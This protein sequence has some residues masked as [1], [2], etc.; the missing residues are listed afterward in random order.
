MRA[1]GL[2]GRTASLRRACR[3]NVDRR[4]GFLW[5][6]GL[7]FRSTF[8]GHFLRLISSP[9]RTRKSFEPIFIRQAGRQPATLKYTL[10]VLR[11]I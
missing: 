9:S 7:L 11:R 3:W 8:V 4:D 10:P 6:Q 1:L 2:K 5:V